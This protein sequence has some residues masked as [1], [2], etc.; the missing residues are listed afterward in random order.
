MVKIRAYLSTQLT[1]CMTPFNLVKHTR[2]ASFPF[3]KN[4]YVNTL[5]FENEPNVKNLGIPDIG[6]YYK[7]CLTASIAMFEKGNKS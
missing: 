2:R 5:T 3:Y 7:V 6:W 1:L 4:I